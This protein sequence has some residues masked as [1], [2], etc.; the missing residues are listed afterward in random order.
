MP[1][2]RD[3]NHLMRLLKTTLGIYSIPLPFDD[4]EFYDLVICDMTLPDFSIYCPFRDKVMLDIENDVVAD[5]EDP[6]QID[7]DSS[8]VNSLLRIP[9]KYDDRPII[10]VMSV[11]PYNSLSNLSMSSSFETLESYQ[12]LACAQE[13]ANLSSAMI[14]P[15]TFEFLPPDKIRLYNNHVYNSKLIA[16]IAYMHHKELFT[17]PTAARQ[18]FFELAKLDA[19]VFLYNTLK[20]YSSITTAYGTIDLKIDEWSNAES[21]RAELTSRWDDLYH[22]DQP[23]MMYI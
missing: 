1:T 19:K 15:K 11:S 21:E 3:K 12:D 9:K 2:F 8:T 22:L 16:E 13:I 14:P 5:W 10:S 17:I 23:N 4:Q 18:S 7:G 20:H 6:V